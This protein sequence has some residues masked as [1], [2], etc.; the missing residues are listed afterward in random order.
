MTTK[1]ITAA[2]AILALSA[3][4][5]AASAGPPNRCVG[6]GGGFPCYDSHGNPISEGP[7]GPVASTIRE[8][9]SVPDWRG[10]PGGI[11]NLTTRHVSCPSARRFAVRV[12]DRYPTPRHWDGFTCRSFTYPG[13][14]LFDIRCTRGVQVIHW[15]G[16]D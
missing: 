6:P 15:Q 2:L 1:M 11:V 5:A 12:T 16:G 3:V 10:S 8:C 7:T 4:P 13:G 9:G 14:E